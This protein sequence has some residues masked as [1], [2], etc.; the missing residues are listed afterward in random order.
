V[1]NEDSSVELFLPIASHMARAG[2]FIN[3]DGYV[4]YS[5]C[6]I[7]LHPETKPL[8]SIL[9]SLLSDTI[10]TCNDVW[11]HCLN[12]VDAFR[13]VSFDALS[14]TPKIDA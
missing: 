9:S 14:H 7:A 10:L 3:I 12:E 8:L 13:E 2:S 4:Q 1:M 11:E 6:A 5:A